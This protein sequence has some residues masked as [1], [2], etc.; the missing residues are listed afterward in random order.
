MTRV[1]FFGHDAADA[2]VRRRVQGFRDDGLDVIGFMMRRVGEL[3]PDWENVD[4]GRTYD[5]AYGQ[6][7]LSILEGATAAARERAKLASADIIYARN[8]DMLATAFLAKRYARLKTPVIYEALDVH[9]LLTRKDPIGLTLRRIEGQLLSR[10]RRLVVSSPSFLANHF[11]RHHRGRFRARLIENRL[12]ANATYGPR[13]DRAVPREADREPLRI[14]WV[15]VLRCWRS[16]GLLLEVA[17]KFGGSVRIV[18]HGA[19]ALTEIPDFHHRIEGLTNVEYHGR[20]TAPEDLAGIYAGLDVVW[21][22]D[23]MEAGYNSVWLL[24][25]R[26]YEGGYYAVPSIAPARTQTATWIEERS[27]GFTVEENLAE[28][29]PALVEGLLR[30]RSPI[31][32]KRG[33]L[34]D[35]PDGTFV[36]PPGEFS[37]LIEEALRDIRGAGS[38][39]LAQSGTTPTRISAHSRPSAA[40]TGE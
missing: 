38:A 27:A 29:L 23:F 11:E 40:A 7:I 39:D 37:R 10:C 5:A 6:R 26:L 1:A 13:P 24:P 34:L 30:D 33:R 14:G 35:L 20:Y 15:G 21:A 28:T 2:A 8:L 17:R 32:E 9:R 22:G 19:P 3:E 12:A 31:L 18:M 16:F 25:N 4:L 36:Q